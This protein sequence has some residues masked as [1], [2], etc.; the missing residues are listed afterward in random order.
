MRQ[1]D[2][3]KRVVEI[4]QIA[5]P[6]IHGTDA[7]TRVTGINPF[8]VDQPLDRVLERSNIVVAERFDAKKW[9]QKRRRHPRCEKTWCAEQRNPEG[10]SMIEH[11]MRYGIVD[12]DQRKIRDRKWTQWRGADRLPELP[13][14]LDTL[15]RWIASDQGGVYCAD[16]HPG[17]PIRMKVRLCESLVD[18]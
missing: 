6:N 10:P 3:L 18:A 1:L 12:F 4:S 14:P 8:E 16:G 5:S 13:Q 7:E 2:L 9:K 17:D 11:R 15:F